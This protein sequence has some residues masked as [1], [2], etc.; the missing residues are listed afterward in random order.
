MAELNHI[1][2]DINN[3][4]KQLTIRKMEKITQTDIDRVIQ[5]LQSIQESTKT[6]L[7][8]KEEYPVAVGQVLGANRFNKTQLKFVINMLKRLEA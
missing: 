4:L 1:F 5:L 8:E 3:Q 6:E 7:N 2:G